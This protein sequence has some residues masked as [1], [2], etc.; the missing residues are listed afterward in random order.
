M[1]SSGQQATYKMFK[2]WM[3]NPTETLLAIVHSAVKFLHN[4]PAPPQK[5]PVESFYSF[6]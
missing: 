1:N 5:F 6:Y 3:L 4:S 2:T